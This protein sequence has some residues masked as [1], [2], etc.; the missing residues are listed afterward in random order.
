[1]L[2]VANPVHPELLASALDW[3][4]DAGVD[5]LIDEVPVAWLARAKAPATAPVTAKT[6][7]TVAPVPS[8]EPMP[9]DHA[10]FVNWLMTSPNVPEAGPS[11][12]RVT[13]A[14][15]PAAPIMILIDM[16]EQGDAAKGQ[17]L[18]GEASEL[19]EK[20]LG[21]IKQTRETIYLACLCPGRPPGGM[22][23]EQAVSALTPI[24]RHHIDLIGPKRLWLMGQTVSRALIG[25]DAMPGIGSLRKVN[26]EGRNVEAVAS[27]S[28]RFLLQQPKRKAAAWLDMQALVEGM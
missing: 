9:K 26:H 16:P 3:W 21:A 6:A 20:M 8:L 28:P 22:L 27:F 7:I 5:T 24:L 2:E 4:V 14:G 18:C 25:A 11:S 15:D 1:M 10:T 23:S 17:L 12:Q 19:F 13:P